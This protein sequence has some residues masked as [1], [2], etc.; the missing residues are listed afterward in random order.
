MTTCNIA[1]LKENF[2]KERSSQSVSKD[3]QSNPNNNIDVMEESKPK[4]LASLDISD[5]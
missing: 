5:L 2:E 4:R 1:K 3:N